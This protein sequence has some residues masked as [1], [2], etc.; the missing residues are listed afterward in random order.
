MN[1]ML[2]SELVDLFKKGLEWSKV[3]EGESVLIYTD[4]NF[5]FPEYVP[6]TFAAARA[7]GAEAY[8]LT[9]PH[10]PVLAKDKL[11][12]DA[13]KGADIVIHLAQPGLWIY[14]KEH[15]EV[16][17]S[18][19]RVLAIRQRASSLRSMFPDQKVIDRC[20]AAGKRL[21]AA[22]EI[23]VTSQAGTDLVMNREGR[24]VHIQVGVADQPGMWDNLGSGI[25]AC[26]PLED[27]T[28]G[29][30]VI[31]P[32]DILM[33]MRW[34]VREPITLTFKEGIVV[35]IKGGADAMM[36]RDYMDRA[37][38][39][40]QVGV[41]S[42]TG[43]GPVDPDVYRVAHASWG[44]HRGADWRNPWSQD[45]ESFYGNVLIALGNN[46]F[47]TPHVNRGMGGANSCAGH[48][49]MDLRNANLFLDGAQIIENGSI[50]P[51]D[52]R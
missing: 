41:K 21:D 38:S 28:E 46:M 9:G 22:R 17:Q 37:Q 32:G 20:Y 2:G 52:L 25:V 29:K 15:N 36:F 39:T 26:A 30:L 23:R 11:I 49:D 31:A 6:A 12:L 48:L 33:Q 1:T 27:R 18:G 19:T 43:K 14:T 8:V 47:D 7:L 5:A 13:W 40:G 44:M 34:Y 42:T 10:R 3:K 45:A 16:L 4:T 51:E 24:K 50:V 35:D